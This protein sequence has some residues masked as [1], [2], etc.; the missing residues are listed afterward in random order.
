MHKPVIITKGNWRGYVGVVKDTSKDR[1]TVELQTNAQ[2]IQVPR[3]DVKLQE[4]S[5]NL[6]FSTTIT[7]TN[8]LSM[9]P[10][11]PSMSRSGI[12]STPIS[13]AF[14]PGRTPTHPSTPGNK[15]LDM[16]DFDS[17]YSSPTPHTPRFNAQTPGVQE[18]PGFLSSTPGTP[19]FGHHPTTPS[20]H[21]PP[22]TPG[23]NAQTPTTPGYSIMNAPN[24]PGIK[25]STPGILSHESNN[26]AVEEENNWWFPNI[27]VVYEGK[28]GVISNVYMNECTVKYKDGTRAQIEGSLLKP[29]GVKKGDK[30]IVIIG[31]NKGKTGGG[32]QRI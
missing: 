32:P 27:E 14:N 20:F 15:D 21:P 23:F 6:N 10:R 28:I 30:G 18:S 19:G 25:P 17:I 29:V 13:L 5:P 16:G 7:K 4:S 9:Q 8:D 22:T 11:T 2:K 24:T 1:V 31:E 26:F 12:P 3:S